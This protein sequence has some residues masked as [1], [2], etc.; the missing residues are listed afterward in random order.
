MNSR[1]RF[2]ATIER[3][4]VDRPAAWLGMPDIHSQPA[5][6]AHYGVKTLHELKLNVGDDFY[7]IELPYESPTASAIYAA[8]D[9]YMDGNVD[10]ENRTLTADG[11][12]KD[13]EEL[14]DL[15][16]FQWPDP[17]QYIDV[18]ECRR[19]AEAAPENKARLGMIWCAH[20]QDA[21]ASFG[22][23]TALMNM[24]ANPELYEAVDQKILEFYLKANEIFFEA[25][26]GKLDAVLIGN[27]IGS[28]R[29]PMISPA[30]VRRFVLPGARKLVEQAHSYGLKVIYHSCG[31]I[32]EVIPDLIA[33]GVDA[34]HP[35]QA[36]AVG[37]SAENLRARFSGQV[38]FCGGVDTQELLVRGTPAQV[39]A[40]VR[41][42][43]RLFPTGLI[44]SPSHEA[45]LPDV[46]PENIRALFEEAQ[47]ID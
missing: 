36:L 1:E 22:M 2:L 47:K 28:Q 45:I 21:C 3:R 19:R 43:R 41:E 6:F 11:C 7:A 9:W 17:A 18:A 37:M 4:P 31:S 14:E 5:L 25:T 33:C 13:A 16:F 27:D 39:A 8:F 10:A 38:S 32:V 29:G 34:I 35:I 40:R 12:F 24:A 15:A 20:F 46:P 30:M 26:R 23:E 44:I 42:L